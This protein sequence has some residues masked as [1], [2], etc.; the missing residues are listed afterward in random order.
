MNPV[1]R[2]TEHIAIN[3]LVHNL[4]MHL[5]RN[6]RLEVSE[7]NDAF[8]TF[9]S[10]LSGVRYALPRPVYDGYLSAGALRFDNIPGETT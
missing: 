1:V 5:P 8:V 4:S 10:V 6:T 9:Q 3:E 7:A 2:T